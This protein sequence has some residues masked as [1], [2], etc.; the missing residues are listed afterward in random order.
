MGMGHL[1]LTFLLTIAISGLFA[2]AFELGTTAPIGSFCLLVLLI[3]FSAVGPK[4]E[5]DSRTTGTRFTV[6][7]VGLTCLLGGLAI[8]P[9]GVAPDPLLWSLAIAGIAAAGLEAADGWLA[10]ITE[11]ASGFSERLGEM[12]AALLV[13]ALAL[14]VWRLGIADLWVL[15]AGVLGFGER[16]IHARNPSVKRPDW[17]VWSELALR[18]ALAVALIPTL[19]GPIAP[20]LAGLAVLITVG[21]TAFTV[22]GPRPGASA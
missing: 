21:Q 15:A 4:S 7:R 20:A 18:T 2:L 22:M 6:A 13:L 12:T 14:L 5:T 11:S 16:A 1:P 17:R 3:A 19:P 8:I 9:A 10:R